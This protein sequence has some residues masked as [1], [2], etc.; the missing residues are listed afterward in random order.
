MNTA[1]RVALFDPAEI[2]APAT[3]LDPAPFFARLRESDPVHW[4]PHTQ[5]WYVTT[6][7]DVGALLVSDALRARDKSAMLAALPAERRARYASVESFLGKWL[8]FSDPPYQLKARTAIQRAFTPRALVEFSDTL[9]THAAAAAAALA[10]GPSDLFGDVAL[11]FALD[12]VCSFLGIR[13]E[14]RA[15][16]LAWSGRLIAYLALAELDDRT[17]EGAG[18]AAKELTEFVTRTVLPRADAPMA[19]LLNG[20]LSSGLLDSLDV[21]ALFA[22]MLTGGVEPTATTAAYG[23]WL[24]ASEPEQWKAV[25]AGEVGYPAAVDEILRLASPFHFAPRTARH[26]LVVRG[27]GIAAGQRVVLVLAAA[28]RDPAVYPSPDAFDVRRGGPG[29]LAFGR[30]GHFCLGAALVRQ[31][32]EALVRAVQARHPGL[33]PGTT[34]VRRRPA[35]GVTSLAEVPCLV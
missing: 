24:L 10:P 22:Q 16:V 1:Q 4:S 14:E 31:A 30:G 8:V 6:Y 20:V 9:R 32:V 34:P 23:L 19:A 17:A 3:A 25:Q 27:R 29:Q 5:S 13:S 7:T 12:L 11:P 21:T 28:N 33:R 18:Q 35:F 2:L 26:D 15:A